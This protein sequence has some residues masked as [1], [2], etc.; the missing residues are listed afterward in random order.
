MTRDTRQERATERLKVARTAMDRV[1]DNGRAPDGC[2]PEIIAIAPARGVAVAFV[3]SRIV[4]VGSNGTAVIDR[5]YKGRKALQVADIFHQINAAITKAGAKEPF[6][7]RQI[8][9]ARA[10][11]ELTERHQASGLKCS[12]AFRDD[13]AGGG[14]GGRD[15][16]ERMLAM[17]QKLDQCH[18][19]IGSGIAKEIRRQRPSQRAGGGVV[20]KQPIFDRDLVDMV[21]VQGKSLRGALDAR[22]WGP[23]RKNINA[24]YR[25]LWAALERLTACF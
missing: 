5:G 18:R 15:V 9:A 10:Y 3:P 16:L 17:R 22:G 4:N 23:D 8:N 11:A 14:C 25:A 24:L 12:S 20:I 2:G 21:C 1:M 19:A 6:T 13:S 7:D